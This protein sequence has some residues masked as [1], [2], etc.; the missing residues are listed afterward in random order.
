M[1]GIPPASKQEAPML[2][3]QDLIEI[4]LLK[5]QAVAGR[6]MTPPRASVLMC[7]V[8]SGSQVS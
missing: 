4:E 8:L 2:T 5:L 1:N 7:R 6:P 3:V